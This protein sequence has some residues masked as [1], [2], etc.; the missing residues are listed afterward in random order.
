MIFEEPEHLPP[1]RGVFDHKIR[2]MPGAKPVNSRPYRYPL[3]QKDTIEQLVQEMLDR[4]IIQHSDSPYASRV[5]LVGK[6]DGSWTR[7]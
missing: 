7:I 4:G 2:V 5:V 6:K 3:K 1:F